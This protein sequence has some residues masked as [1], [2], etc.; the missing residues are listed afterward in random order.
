MITAIITFLSTRIVSVVITTLIVVAAVPT[1]IV[2]IHGNTITITTGPVAS[3]SREHGDDEHARIVLEI[4]NAG[5][6]VILRINNEEAS[7]D[8]QIAQLASGTKLSAAATKA[9]LDRGK[10][11]F[12]TSA[13]HFLTELRDDE[14]EASHLRVITTQTEQII[15]LQI[16]TVQ[17]T[18]LGDDAHSG[19]LV[20]TCSTV[21]IEIRQIIITV[22]HPSGGEGDD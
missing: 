20:T 8:S 6:A 19:T 14:D 4:K 16:S 21:L 9:A 12:H 5:D 10:S 15:L 3:A 17:L 13:A 18:A 7:C 11:E 22:V 2:A 1:L